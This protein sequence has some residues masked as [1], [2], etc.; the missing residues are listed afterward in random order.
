MHRS[1]TSA[2][3]RCLKVF[4]VELGSQLLPPVKGHNDKGYWEDITFNAI[5]R[6]LISLLGS[7]FH[8]LRLS[9]LEEFSSPKFFTIKEKAKSLILNKLKDSDFIGLKDPRTCLVLPFWNSILDEL[10]VDVKYI[11]ALRDPEAVAKSFAKAHGFDK[12]KCI[13]LWATYTFNSIKRS[14]LNNAIIVRYENLIANPV[15]QLNR[16]SIFLNI[17]LHD[18]TESVKN[19]CEVFLD[20]MLQHHKVKKDNLQSLSPLLHQFYCHL[21]DCS[22]VKSQLNASIDH[23]LLNKM[24]SLLSRFEDN[25]PIIEMY[26][27]NLSEVKEKFKEMKITQDLHKNYISFLCL[28]EKMKLQ[29]EILEAKIELQSVMLDNKTKQ[30][31]SLISH[32]RNLETANNKLLNS[33]YWKITKPLRIVFSLLRK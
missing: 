3:T 9:K 22:G 8:L 13:M 7:D 23:K 6:E 4:N 5:N 32:I 12:G 16:L 31:N 18:K 19:Y 27:K 15:K 28:E 10:G 33:T 14:N 21:S 29:T 2:I 20:P 30:E 25:W 1:G 24:E 26:E 11:V 17:S